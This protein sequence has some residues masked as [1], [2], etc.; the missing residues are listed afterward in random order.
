MEV[1]FID[2]NEEIGAMR[3]NLDNEACALL[4]Q[5]KLNK[6]LFDVEDDRT[7][8]AVSDEDGLWNVTAIEMSD[9][10]ITIKTESHN[11]E[12]DFMDCSTDDMVA[13][14]E[15]IYHHVSNLK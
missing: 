7:S 5:A 6:I 10:T 9:D 3:V 14:Y 11:L 12:I 8:L 13:V 1:K 15:A 2:F 4:R